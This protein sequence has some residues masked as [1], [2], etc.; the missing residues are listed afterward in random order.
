MAWA[1]GLFDGE[2]SVSLVD[3]WLKLQLKMTDRGAVERFARIV[4]GPDRVLG[5]YVNRTGDKDGYPR[6]DFYMWVSRVGEG[7][8]IL[9][10]LWPYLSEFR[11]ARA[12][13]LGYIERT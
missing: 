3:G 7:R 11:R 4:T 13:E 5:P 8:P 2:G 1:A 6:K 10:R 9:T 12:R